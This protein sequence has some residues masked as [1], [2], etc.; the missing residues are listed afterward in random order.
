MSNILIANLI[1]SQFKIYL[2][3]LYHV[4]QLSICLGL[5]SIKMNKPT[6]KL[7]YI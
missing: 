6:Y 4:N 5:N 3:F 1:K 7:K 2:Q